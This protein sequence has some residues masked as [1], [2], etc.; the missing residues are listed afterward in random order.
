M[1]HLWLKSTMRSQS[2]RIGSAGIPLSIFYRFLN[3]E[4]LPGD[5][6]GVFW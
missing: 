5:L 2:A 1:S 3:M 4:T 6:D